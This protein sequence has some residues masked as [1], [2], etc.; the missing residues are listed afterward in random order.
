MPAGWPFIEIERKF[1]VCSD[2]WRAKVFKT[3]F[4][5]QSY[6]STIPGVTSRVR[7]I[8]DLAYLTFKTKTV[9]MSR[10][11]IEFPIATDLAAWLFTICPHPVIEK[12]RHLVSH[13]DVTWEVDVFLARHLGLIVAEVELAHPLQAITLPE[14]IGREVTSDPRY[15]NSHIYRAGL[16]RQKKKQHRPRII[17]G[18]SQDQSVPIA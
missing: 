1:L 9:G 3:S 12:E 8:D 17:K 11:E 15:K 13:A 16:P 5:R 14:W 10:G 7:Q 4:I 18:S 6:L 2:S